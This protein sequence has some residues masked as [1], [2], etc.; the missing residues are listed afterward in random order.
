MIAAAIDP[1]SLMP[2]AVELIRCGESFEFDLY[3]RDGIAGKPVLYR[4]KS[5][6]IQQSDLQALQRRGIRTLFIESDDLAE[7]ER[8]LHER[9]LTDPSASDDARFCAVREA[10]RSVFLAALH[11]KQVGRV[12]EVAGDLAKGLAD[13]VCSQR[14]TVNELFKLLSHDYYTYTHVTNVCVYTLALAQHLGINSQAELSVIA[15]GGLL[16]DLGKRYIPL[17]ILNKKGKLTDQEFAV[18]KRHPLDGFRE[19]CRREDLSWDQLMMV[20][21]HHERLDGRGYPARVTAEE[22]LPW[23][24][25]CAIADVFDALTS[26]RPYRGPMPTEEVREFFRNNSGSAFDKEMV[27]CWDSALKLG[28]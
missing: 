27:H 23:S 10:S 12:V 25:M 13:A 6:P 28:A 3:L 9:V 8:Y 4:G 26:H 11:E 17:D 21:Q 18:V 2:I 14:R 19:L 22:I 16:H 15:T 1:A 7:Y 20:Y 24:R 5:F